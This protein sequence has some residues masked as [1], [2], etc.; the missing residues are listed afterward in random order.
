MIGMTGV[1]T[2]LAG[3]SMSL[4]IGCANRKADRATLRSISRID[5]LNGDAPLKRLILDETPQLSE[6]PGMMD[7]PLPL[8]EPHALPD[9]TQILKDDQIAA[10]A[11]LYDPSA[12]DMVE[13]GHPSLLFARKPYQEALG[14]FRAFGLEMLTKLM[15]MAANIDSL[16]ARKLKPVGRRGDIMDTPI[17]ADGIGAIRDTHFTFKDE[18]DVEASFGFLVDEH[19]GGGI[20]V[21][22]QGPL[23][24]AQG[25]LQLQ[26]AVHGRDGNKLEAGDE[27]EEA[28]IQVERAALEARR[29]P[30]PFAGYPGNGTDNVVGGK[31]V[32]SLKLMIAKAVKLIPVPSLSLLRYG[33]RIVAGLGESGDSLKQGSPRLIVNYKSALNGLNQFHSF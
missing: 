29:R 3:E 27:P 13:I 17:D 9:K 25:E 10:L 6:R 23:E 2:G 7:T 12:D 8:G 1:T 5:V 16:F 24:V 15:I 21:F 18:V 19:S 30:S 20:L 31:L 26:P 14:P 33:E 28:F 11:G 4:P 32:S 22:E